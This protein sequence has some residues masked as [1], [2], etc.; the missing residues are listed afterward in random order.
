MAD[1]NYYPQ[2]QDDGSQ[3][4]A[5]EH[6]KVYNF[7]LADKDDASHGNISEWIYPG[8]ATH[9]Y[10]IAQK[11][12]CHAVIRGSGDSSGAPDNHYAAYKAGAPTPYATA[13]NGQAETPGQMGMIACDHIPHEFALVNTATTASRVTLYIRY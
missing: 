1:K 13:Y 9:I 4:A 7:T 3:A 11:S 6:T 2:R 10:W 12:N 8:N 5:L